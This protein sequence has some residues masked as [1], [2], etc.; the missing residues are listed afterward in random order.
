MIRGTT[1]QFKFKLPYNIGDLDVVKITFWQ[2][3]YSGPDKSRPLPIVKILEQCSQSD[4][5]ELT[6]IL[7]KEE[8]LRFIDDRKAYVQFRGKTIDGTAFASKQEIITV[9]P[10]HD[11]SILE[12]DIIPTPNPEA[13]GIIILDGST[14]E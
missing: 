1:A 11:D 8:T 2:N 9:Y 5:D 7:N 6:V 14:I 3:G 12:D 10:V 13:D 4:I